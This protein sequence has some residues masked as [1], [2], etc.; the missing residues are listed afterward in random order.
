MRHAFLTA[1]AVVLAAA[2]SSKGPAG[3]GTGAQDELVASDVGAASF[4]PGGGMYVFTSGMNL[5]VRKVGDE[6]TFLLTK[7]PPVAVEEKHEEGETGEEAEAPQ[8]ECVPAEPNSPLPGPQGGWHGHPAW[9]P[10][11]R[12]IAFMAPWEDGN[13]IDGDDGDWDIWLVNVDG[14]DLDAWVIEVAPD[15]DQPEKKDHYIVGPEGSG[16]T[17]FQV[18]TLEGSEQRPVWADCRTLAYTARDGVYMK[19]LTSIPGICEKT[20]AELAAEREARIEKLDADV[21]RLKR[22]VSDLEAKVT[23]MQKPAEPEAE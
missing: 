20:L 21:S 10:D 5:A 12:F 7:S 15:K 8:A 19:D 4:A 13:C 18:S 6:R 3:E 14:L 1:I 11:G 2:C 23:A 16:L 17:Y 22:Q 9:S